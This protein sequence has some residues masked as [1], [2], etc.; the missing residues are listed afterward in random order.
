[1]PG[2]SRRELLRLAGVGL[3]G[4]SASGWLQG[5][6]AHAASDPNRRKSCILLWMSGGPSQID[7]FDPKPGHENNGPGTPI[8]TAVPGILFGEHLPLMA[9]QAADLAI[10]RGMSTKEGDHGRATYNL[11]TGYPQQG[12]VRYPT[13]GALISKEL[14]DESAELPGFVSIAPERGISPGA[15]GPGFL[16]PRYAPLVVGERNNGRGSFRVDDLQPPGEVDRQRSDDR[17]GLMQA[18]AHDFQITRPGIAPASHQ[19]AYVRAVKMMRSDAARAFDLDDEPD[20][21]RDAY[22]RNPFGQGCL[23]ARRLVERGVPFIELTMSSADG[24]N[25]LGWDTHAQNFDTVA[26]LCGALDGGWVAL[27]NDLRSRGLLDSTMIVWMGE[28]GRTPKINENA[29]RDH[30]PNAWSAVLAG[31]GLKG[32]QAIGDTGADGSEVHDRPVAVP[33]LLATIVKGLGLDPMTQNMAENGRPIRLV[34]PKAKPIHEV[35]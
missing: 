23:L 18:F 5:L 20:A 2:P 10:I 12:P 31:G 27:M 13:F 14:E 24:Q 28:F 16:G 30:Y 32:G 25:Q 29:G 21:V 7:T 19:D 35:L 6:A 9:K 1:M 33:D 26:T 3:L 15:F 4:G 34:D 22:G 11:R 8:E 17:L